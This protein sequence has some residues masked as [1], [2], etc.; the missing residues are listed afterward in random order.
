MLARFRMFV[1]V[2][3]LTV[4]TVV[5]VNGQWATWCDPTTINTCG[6]WPD[7]ECPGGGNC[8]SSISEHT[9]LDAWIEVCVPISCDGFC[10]NN[11]TEA[12]WNFLR[13]Y[14]I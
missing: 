3:C 10:Q 2:F 6:T 14:C 8:V 7:S 9:C 1:T 4:A 12:C 13:E 11:P 5:A